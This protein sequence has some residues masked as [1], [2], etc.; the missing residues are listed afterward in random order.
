MDTAVKLPEARGDVAK[1]PKWAQDH[2]RVLRM[3]LQEAHERLADG[4]EDSNVIADPYSTPPL[5]LARDTAIRFVL[6]PTGTRQAGHITVSLRD[7]RL[8]L[9]GTVS[10]DVRPHSGNVVSV[11]LPT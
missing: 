10:I 11:G 2:V 1:L 7:G 4:P 6:E 9:M 5:F 8:N 3:R